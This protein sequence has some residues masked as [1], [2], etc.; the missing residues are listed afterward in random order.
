MNRRRFL[1]CLSSLPAASLAVPGV[2]S[3]EPN[4]K[5]FTEQPG[6]DA[7]SHSD[8]QL[9]VGIMGVGG[10]GVFYLD[11]VVRSFNYPC[12]HI[13]IAGNMSYLRFSRA[14]N[15]VLIANHGSQSFFHPQ[16]LPHLR[17]AAS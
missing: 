14:E 5:S 15:A 16:R 10:P 11:R 9:H 17:V 8:G 2:S 6:R 4:Q 7:Q 1:Y 12:R 3:W 13:A